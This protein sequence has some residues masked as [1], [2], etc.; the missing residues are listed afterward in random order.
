MLNLKWC[1]RKLA[2]PVLRGYSSIRLEELMKSRKSIR[3]EIR[4]WNV[5]RRSADY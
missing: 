4:A 3:A 1:A 5:V 2:F